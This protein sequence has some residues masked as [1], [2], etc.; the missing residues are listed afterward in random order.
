MRGFNQGIEMPRNNAVAPACIS[1][2]S[3]RDTI[4]SYFEPTRVWKQ[5]AGP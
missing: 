5:V 1:S 3:F 2:Q 4:K